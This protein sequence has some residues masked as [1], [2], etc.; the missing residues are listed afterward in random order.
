MTI[1]AGH[2][3]YTIANTQD[4]QKDTELE[5]PEIRSAGQYLLA[6]SG[7]PLIQSKLKRIWRHA[8]ISAD[9]WYL[10]PSQQ[11]DVKQAARWHVTGLRRRAWECPRVAIVVGA[12]VLVGSV[13]SDAL[14]VYAAGARRAHR[15]NTS[16][17][18]P[19]EYENFQH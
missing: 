15:P 7:F 3:L 16:T 5:R 19:V 14:V 1:I 9:E 13:F 12:G 8:F 10:T 11:Q 6:L 4:W 18:H 17:T 2:I